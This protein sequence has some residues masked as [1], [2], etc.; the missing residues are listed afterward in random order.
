[1]RIRFFLGASSSWEEMGLAGACLASIAALRARL[2]CWIVGWEVNKVE[3]YGWCCDVLRCDEKW[4]Q[5][6]WEIRTKL[7]CVCVRVLRNYGTITVRQ[8]FLMCHEG[9]WT[10]FF[11]DHQTTVLMQTSTHFM[12]HLHMVSKPET[13]LRLPLLRAS[14]LVLHATRYPWMSGSMTWRKV[15]VDK[16]SILLIAKIHLITEGDDHHENKW[17]KRLL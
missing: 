9:L 7:G 4:I 8:M 2:D 11:N 6:L 1:M 14:S 3:M 13:Q 16:W 12:T 17:N 15:A 5:C 10:F